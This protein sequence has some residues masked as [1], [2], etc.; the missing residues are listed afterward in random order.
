MFASCVKGFGC[1]NS[2]RLS[3]VTAIDF[4]LR[5]EC[6]TNLCLMSSLEQITGQLREFANERDWNQFHS[7]KNLILAIV[8]EVGELASEVQWLTSQEME[9]RKS[10]K[11]IADE[12]ADIALYLIRLSDV[13]GID[14]SEAISR[15]LAENA[16]KYPVDKSRGNAL[17]YDKLT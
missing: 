5:E 1:P 15:K 13:L 12:I 2:G 4:L 16:K 8:G 11:A 14:L 7:A 3:K 17:K 6:R 10:D 9:N